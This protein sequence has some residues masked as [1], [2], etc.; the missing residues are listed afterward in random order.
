MPAS[1]S[2]STS[3]RGPFFLPIALLP[4]PPAWTTAVTPL[5][6]S[7]SCL[8]PQCV[9]H[10]AAR[11]IQ[12]S[13]NL[14][15]LCSPPSRG[16]HLLRGQSQSPANSSQRPAQPGHPHASDLISSALPTTHSAP[17]TFISWLFLQHTFLPQALC[18][19]SSTCLELFPRLAPACPSSLNCFLRQLPLVIHSIPQSLFLGFVAFWNDIV[20]L[21][22]SMFPL[23]SPSS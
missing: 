22:V 20:L 12:I 16:F 6:L 18:T 2:G 7:L 21:L 4:P 3:Q 1:P 23:I 15:L 9:P 10:T 17:A 13:L 11:R 14:S 8:C 19:C 5:S